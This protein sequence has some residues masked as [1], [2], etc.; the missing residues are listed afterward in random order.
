MSSPYTYIPPD[1]KDKIYNVLES[2]HEKY[3]NLDYGLDEYEQIVI[4]WN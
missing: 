2:L 3:N 4:W 1:I